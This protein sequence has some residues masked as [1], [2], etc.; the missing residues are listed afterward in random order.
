[1]ISLRLMEDTME[2]YVA[3]CNWFYT[4]LYTRRN[5]NRA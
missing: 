4:I 3:M 2:D 5:D 1:M